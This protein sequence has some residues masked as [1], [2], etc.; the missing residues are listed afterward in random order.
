[1]TE[2]FALSKN[3]SNFV[4]VHLNKLMK[5]GGGI[6]PD[7]TLATLAQ[8]KVPNPIPIRSGKDKLVYIRTSL[9]S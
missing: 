1:M 2:K 4:A 6:R 9:C 3:R 5:K 7:E 8:E